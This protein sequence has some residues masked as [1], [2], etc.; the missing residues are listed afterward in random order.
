MGQGEK[1]IPRRRPQL[2]TPG[3]TLGRSFNFSSGQLCYLQNKIWS[4]NVSVRLK[5]DSKE[6]LKKVRYGH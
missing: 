4:Q 3:E 1:G 5:Y 6:R 2:P